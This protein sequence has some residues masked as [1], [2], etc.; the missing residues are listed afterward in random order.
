MLLG[1]SIIAKEERDKT[2]EF[3]D[4]PACFTTT[5]ITSKLLTALVNIVIV[6]IVTLFSSIAMVSAYNKGEDITGEVVVFLFSMF[7]VQLIFLSL[8]AL[9]S[10]FMRNPKKSGSPSYGNLLTAYVISKVTDLTDKVNI[11]NVLSPLKYFDYARIVN[12]NGLNF[13]IVILSFVMVA[14]FSYFTYF[15]YSRRDLNI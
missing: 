8:G 11:L 3:L 13:V 5:I 1:S 2:T 7:I 4:H 14:V 9:L 12:G 6:N 15:F 10:A